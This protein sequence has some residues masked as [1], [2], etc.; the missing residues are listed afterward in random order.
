MLT[1]EKKKFLLLSLFD[2]IK[3]LKFNLD[4]IFDKL[5]RRLLSITEISI[6]SSFSGPITDF[7]CNFSN[8]FHDTRWLFD[9]HPVT[10]KHYPDFQGFC[11]LSGPITDFSCNFQICFHDHPV[12]GKQYSDLHRLFLLQSDHRFFFGIFQKFFMILDGFR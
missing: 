12:T 5:K 9:S 11:S 1:N 8:V 2:V 10:G 7:Y 4:V 6:C 3:R